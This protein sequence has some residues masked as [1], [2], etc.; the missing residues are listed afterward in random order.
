MGEAL[1]AQPFIG[2]EALK[3]GTVSWYELGKYHTAIMPNVYLDKR[4]EPTL[5][6]RIVAAWLWSRR[7]AVI[8]GTSAAAMHGARWV[9]NSLPVELI[10]KN[11][12]TPRGVKTRDELLLENETQR[13]SAMRVT[14]PVRTAFDLARRPGA[15]GPSIARLDALAGATGFKITDVEELA[16]RHRRCRGLRQMEAALGLI[17]P[18]AQSPKETWLRLL[19]INAGYPK[20]RTQIPVLDNGYPKY[21]LDLGWEHLK[22][23]VEYDGDQHRTS[24]Y[25][26]VKDVE[27]LEFISGA[28]W[29]LIRV[30]AEHRASEILYRVRRAWDALTLR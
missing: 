22:L 12:R 29:T 5:R 4:L 9:D 13:L 17:D 1:G 27:R 2:S 10:W 24:R 16:A 14:T 23:A 15:L 20:P 26:Y 6:Q 28:G 18:G 25:Q 30:L 21:F 19:I 8:S 7:E 3:A 11:A